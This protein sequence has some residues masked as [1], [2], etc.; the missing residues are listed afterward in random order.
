LLFSDNDAE[1]DA[2]GSDTEA[3][4]DDV[5]ANQGSVSSERTF[6]RCVVWFTVLFVVTGAVQ[7]SFV[8]FWD[9]F[10]AKF[11]LDPTFSYSELMQ[12]FGL[13]FFLHNLVH[14]M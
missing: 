9:D 13:N 1:G 5:A 8:L 2:Q 14:I 11:E 7:L 3:I 4:I 10:A 12:N 6:D